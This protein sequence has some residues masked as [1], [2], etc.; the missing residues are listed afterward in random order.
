MLEYRRN[1]NK[2]SYNK[3]ESGTG[4][5]F[6]GFLKFFGIGI[7]RDLSRKTPVYPDRSGS[8]QFGHSIFPGSGFSGV[9]LGKSRSTIW[10]IPNPGPVFS[11]LP[12]S[13]I[14]EKLIFYI[15]LEFWTF[16]HLNKE[17]NEFW[18]SF[19]F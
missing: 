2:I 12:D 16:G 5:D 1:K 13:T 9:P 19:Y 8:R 7:F 10:Q 3:I 15:L 11:D 6:L 14:K 4:R 17:E 18:F